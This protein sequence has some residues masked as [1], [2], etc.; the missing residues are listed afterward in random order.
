MRRYTLVAAAFLTGF[1]LLFGYSANQVVQTAIAWFHNGG[2]G[3]FESHYILLQMVWL[4]L[5]LGSLGGIGFTVQMLVRSR[6][7]G[8]WYQWSYAICVLSGAVFAAVPVLIATV[9]RIANEF[10]K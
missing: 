3:V 1:V 2:E 8:A 10:S 7:F 9:L 5:C 6:R 4:G